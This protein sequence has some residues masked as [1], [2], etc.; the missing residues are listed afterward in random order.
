MSCF[1]DGLR[2]KLQILAITNTDFVKHLKEQ[3]SFVYTNQ[4]KW[5][6]ATL[7]RKCRIENYYHI[8]HYDTRTINNGYLC[9]VCDPFLILICALFQTNIIHNFNGVCV[10]YTTDT[11]KNTIH[12]KSDANH[13][14]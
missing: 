1:W 4:V 10:R 13:F 7:T 8:K 14:F 6:G 2:S 3:N 5:Q 11:S 9:S 12:C